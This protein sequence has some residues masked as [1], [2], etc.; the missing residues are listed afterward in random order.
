MF[1]DFRNVFFEQ[2]CFSNHQIELVFPNFDSKNLSRW[3]KKS[4]IIKLRNGLYTFPEYIDKPNLN[5][6]LANRLYQ[7]SYISLHFAL[8]FYGII[9]EVINRVTSVSTL[10][11]KQFNNALGEFTFQSVQPKMFFGYEIKKTDLWDVQM[12]SPEKAVVDLFHLFPIYNTLEDMEHLRF[13]HVSLKESINI[14]K[15][16]TYLSLINSSTLTHRIN[17]MKKVYVL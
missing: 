10:K 3:Q 13:D 2:V 17:L 1:Y 9:P 16:D 14:K 5:L 6:Y 4:Y 12:A 15:L 11:S 7:P 8:N